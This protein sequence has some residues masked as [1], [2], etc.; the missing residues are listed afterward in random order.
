MHKTKRPKNFRVVTPR[1]CA[2]CLKY[3]IHP[4]G[5]GCLREG[6]IGDTGDMM[7]YE[8]TCDYWRRQI[9]IE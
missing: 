6:D 7:Q 4:G 2:T 9:N 1:V 3:T 5:W 8:R